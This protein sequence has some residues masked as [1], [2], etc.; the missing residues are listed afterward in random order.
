MAPVRNQRNERLRAFV[1][2]ANR[3][4]ENRGQGYFVGNGRRFVLHALPSG[5]CCVR[6]FPDVRRFLCATPASSGA[7]RARKMKKFT[8]KSER[9]RRLRTLDIWG[10][11]EG[12]EQ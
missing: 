12:I 3:L 5:P 10:L 11:F 7:A 8:K 9:I 4:M 6:A 2:A 1:E